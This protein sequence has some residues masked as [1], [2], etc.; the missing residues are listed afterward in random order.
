MGGLLHKKKNAKYWHRREWKACV[1]VQIVANLSW[2]KKTRS[3]SSHYMEAKGSAVSLKLMCAIGVFLCS[4][5]TV[6]CLMLSIV[7]F[8]FASIV[9]RTQ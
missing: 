5:T 7:A 9:F 8:S 4:Y 2:D 6:L 1:C 3:L